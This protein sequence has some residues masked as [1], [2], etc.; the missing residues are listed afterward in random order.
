MVER[1][2]PVPIPG[3]EYEIQIRDDG[4]ASCRDIMNELVAGKTCMI[5][6]DSNVGPLY[7]EKVAEL[8]KRAGAERVA[9]TSFPAGEPSKN[10][11][12]MAT[13][14]S[15]CVKAGLDRKSLIIALGGGVVGDMAGFLAATYMRGIEFIQ[16]PTSL[17]AHVDSSIGGK[18]GVDLPEGKNLVGAFKQ[19]LHVL[20]DLTC[21]KTL[22]T[23]E[24]RSGL[25][26]V[27]KY[28]MIMD[29]ALFEQL[30]A[31]VDK[32]N[33]LDAE[34][35]AEIIARCC[36]LKADVVLNDEHDLKGLRTILNYGHTFGHALEALAGYEKLTHGEGVAI[37]MMMAADLAAARDSALAEVVERQQNLWTAL[38]LP[39]RAN[40][41]DPQQVME[42]MRSD[43]KY[44]HG[45]SRLILPVAFGKCELVKDVLEAEIIEAIGGR[46]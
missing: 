15:D 31:R 24:L 4:F 38:G 45:K 27:V 33:A 14:Y 8:L 39:T 5:V 46:V 44:E 11:N 41:F 25:G 23:R 10:L 35:Y 9:S 20:I 12:T 1:T 2:I 43:K 36:E 30:E 34:T 18:T 32:L 6:T 19:P 29:A 17:L 21:L 3:R 22:P 13:L 16:I 26:E 37:G 42:A 7:E 28:G 40:G